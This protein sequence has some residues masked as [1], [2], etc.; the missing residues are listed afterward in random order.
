MGAY[1]RAHF[2]MDAV[3]ATGS[4]PWKLTWTSPHPK[5]PKVVKLRVKLAAATFG[6]AVEVSQGGTK[7]SQE[8]DGSFVIDFMKLSMDVQKGGSS[9]LD[10]AKFLSKAKVHVSRTGSLLQ[11]A[12]LPQGNYSY[13]LRTLAGHE[14]RSGSLVSQGPSESAEMP[15]PQGRSGLVLVLRNAASVQVTAQVPPSI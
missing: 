12:G 2:V 3:T 9:I 10:E 4:G 5:M 11:V 1:Y 8:S 15:A 13:S 7:I 14:V 6:S